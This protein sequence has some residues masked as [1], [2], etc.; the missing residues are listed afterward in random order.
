[1][2]YCGMDDRQTVTEE[3]V[4][5]DLEYLASL[6]LVEEDQDGRW[7]KTPWAALIGRV[8]WVAVVTAAQKSHGDN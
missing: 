3:T 4:R 5:G 8:G 6:G 2:L 1:M 7:H